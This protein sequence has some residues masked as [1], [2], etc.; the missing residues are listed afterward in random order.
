MSASQW[1]GPIKN[2]SAE[3]VNI[4]VG[5]INLSTPLIQLL[6]KQKKSEKD[7]FNFNLKSKNLRTDQI[8]AVHKNNSFKTSMRV[9]ELVFYLLM[10][11]HQKALL[12]PDDSLLRLS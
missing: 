12:V 10:E 11:L 6:L 7:L 5:T 9:D 4:D 8:V 1:I 2:S 3:V